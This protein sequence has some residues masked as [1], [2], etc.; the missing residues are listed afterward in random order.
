M[1]IGLGL[2]GEIGAVGRERLFGRSSI[3]RIV[4]AVLVAALKV[5]R[6]RTLRAIVVG[7]ARGEF[8][9]RSGSDHLVFDIALL[10]IIRIV[11]GVICKQG[12][13]FGIRGALSR[14]QAKRHGKIAL[15]GNRERCRARIAGCKGL[16]CPGLVVF[17]V[18]HQGGVD[19]HIQVDNDIDRR[20]ER[21]GCAGLRVHWIAHGNDQLARVDL[22]RPDFDDAG[23]ARRRIARIDGQF[24]IE[25]VGTELRTRQVS[26]NL[27]RQLDDESVP[28]NKLVVFGGTIPDAPGSRSRIQSGAN[29]QACR[30]RTRQHDV[31]ERL[32]RNSIGRAILRPRLIACGQNLLRERGKVIVPVQTFGAK[33]Q[34]VGCRG[35]IACG[36]YDLIICISALICGGVVTRCRRSG[37]IRCRRIGST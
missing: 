21:L 27:G 26:R 29:V 3:E 20:A 18:A 36:K 6:A 22:G 24:A 35:P 15:R 11:G 16:Q 32:C 30:Q 17:L 37:S 5:G 25:A 9:S 23:L 4:Q 33:N 8:L 19:I 7:P 28:C 13:G 14:E 1:Q 34:G 2:V 31:I 12:R 10:G